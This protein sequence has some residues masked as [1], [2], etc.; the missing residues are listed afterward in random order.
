MSHDQKEALFHSIHA[1][2]RALSAS[3][4]GLHVSPH[5]KMI[6]LQHLDTAFL[7][8]KEAFAFMAADKAV[9]EGV[10]PVE[11]VPL[12]TNETEEKVISE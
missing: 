6:I 10:S 4:Q 3:V 5:A 9:T 2:Y 1:Q 11:E 12:E 7:W 8:M